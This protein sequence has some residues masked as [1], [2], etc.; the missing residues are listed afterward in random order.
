MPP[1]MLFSLSMSFEYCSKPKKQ[2][3]QPKQQVYQLKQQIRQAKQRLW[4]QLLNRSRTD[5]AKH[6]VFI[7][8][9]F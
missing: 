5:A 9:V 3:H 1:N 6:P 7:V 4:I 8:N 2:V